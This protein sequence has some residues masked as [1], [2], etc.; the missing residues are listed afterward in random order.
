MK[1]KLLLFAA[2][3]FISFSGF[4]QDSSRSDSRVIFKTEPKVH[5]SVIPAIK[6]TSESKNHIYRP[7]RL[8]SSSPFY[9]TY[10][11]NNYGAGAITTNP[12]KQGGSS[13]ISSPSSDSTYSVPD[14]TNK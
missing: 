2:G 13:P 6:S 8:G 10:E 1:T 3:L 4:S 14:S 5:S 11:K 9:N 7:T 12:N